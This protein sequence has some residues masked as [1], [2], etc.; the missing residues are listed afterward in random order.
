MKALIV[1][2]IQKDFL[3]GG[4]LGVAGGDEIVAVVNRLMEGFP[5]VVATQDWH[6]PDHG[7]F[8]VNNPGKSEYGMGELGGLPQVM[9]PVHCVEGSEGAEFADGLDVGKIAKIFPKGTSAVVDSYS[10][11]FD[12]DGKH[13]TGL[14]EWLRGAGV[15]DVTVCGLAL[16]YCVKFTALDAVKEGFSTSLHLSACRGVNLVPGDVEK[17]VAGMR[18]A[19][20]GIVEGC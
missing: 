12:N 10:G 3:P 4:A 2:D 19:G 8:A 16:D 15:T 5:L 14:A 1:V 13:S 20:V 18:A 6:P 17:A 7:S 9:W 11:F